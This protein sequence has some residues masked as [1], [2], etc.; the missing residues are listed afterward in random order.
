MTDIWGHGEHIQCI[1]PAANC[2][3]GRDSVS[4]QVLDQDA[5]STSNI[6]GSTADPCVLPRSSKAGSSYCVVT[7]KLG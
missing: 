3:E 4:L 2:I 1:H 7:L 5:K 6:L